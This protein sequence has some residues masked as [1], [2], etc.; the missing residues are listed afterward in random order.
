MSVGRQPPEGGPPAERRLDEHL[1]LLR[2]GPPE[3]GRTLRRRTVRT[4]RWQR[5]IRAPLQIVGLIAGALVDGVA[6][7]L[8]TGGRGARR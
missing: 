8:G 3:P 7:L 4:A 5:A 1:E 2:Q 6:Q